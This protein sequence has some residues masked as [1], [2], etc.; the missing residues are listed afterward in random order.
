MKIYLTI[1]LLVSICIASFALYAGI[2]HNAMGEFCKDLDLEVCRFDFAYASFIWF[3]WFIPTY[4][5]QVFLIVASK[6]LYLFL[7]KSSSGR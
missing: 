7:T 6:Y 4:I 2:T 1:A 5:V 3:G